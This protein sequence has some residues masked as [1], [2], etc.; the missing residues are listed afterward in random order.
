MKVFSHAVVVIDGSKFKAVNSRDRNF[1]VGKVKARRKQL[2]ESAARY[3]AELDRADRDPAVLP[4]GLVPCLKEKLAKLRE[5]MDQP[6]VVDHQ[7]DEVPD[8]QISL[9]DPDS[10]SMATRG[11]G[12]RTVGYNVQAAVDAEHHLI[13]SH[14][15]T[16][17]G[18]D[19]AQLALMA[20]KAREELGTELMTALADRGY[21]SESEI[22]AC[23]EAGIIPLVPR[24]GAFTQPRPAAEAVSPAWRSQL[25]RA[26]TRT[27]RRPWARRWRGRSAAGRR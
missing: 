12:T 27:W 22:L 17:V 2:E 19:R 7:L 8:H 18:N 10:Q 6:D 24:P 13:V 11:R 4:E 3:L 20:K 5:Q 23:E 21:V 26:V 25:A 9:A 16:N 15:V 1:T 14:E